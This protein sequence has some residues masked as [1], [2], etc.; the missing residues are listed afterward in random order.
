[1]HL[2]DMV[3][4]RAEAGPDR[5]AIFDS[6]SGLSYGALEAGAEGLARALRDEGVQPGARVAMLARNTPVYPLLMI[7][8]AKAGGIFVPLNTRAAAGTL[9]DLLAHCDPA[10]L[11][12]QDEF[13]PLLQQAMAGARMPRLVV[14]DVDNRA[15]WAR[16]A[17]A[18]DKPLPPLGRD[19]LPG[20]IMYTSGTTG[21]PKGVVTS[22]RNFIHLLDQHVRLCGLRPEDRL[23]LAMP[24]YHNGG[25]A[26]VM[27]AGLR[28]GAAVA[29]FTG[30]FA[31]ETVLAAAQR[32][33]VSVAHWIPTML[34]R[35]V[36]VMEATPT[37]LPA[38]RSVQF[39]AMPITPAL[40]ARVRAAFPV[41]LLQLYGTT[42]CG[43]VACS[44]D[45]RDPGH[46]GYMRLAADSGVRV[47]DDTGAD[48]PVGGSGEV[49]VTQAQSGMIGYWQAPEQ[50]ATAVRNGQVHTGD[51]ARNLGGGR[52]ALVGRRDGMI[53][54]GGE[55]L[56]PG[57]VENAL[58]DHPALREVAVVGVEDPDLGQRVCAVV[59]LRPGAEVTLDDLRAHCAARIPGFM[60][61]RVLRVIAE[62][63]RTATGKISRAEVI[64]L[65]R[66]KK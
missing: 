33:Q 24:L 4:R 32:D 54:S 42:D 14:L 16:V 50:T 64:A 46:A 53:I 58:A 13:L 66:Q 63:P 17:A 7:A 62:L 23:Q 35:L 36:E 20:M 30:S 2:S 49:V 37:A 15:L 43:L 65:A 27:G 6:A 12:V 19:D 45:L 11:V 56:Y 10:V 1:M 39:G 3:V 44:D 40:L 21:A 29:C 47:L 61:P 28:A 41:E 22:H 48:A 18:S 31:A 59:S 8:T 38:L 34:N 51:M 25:M 26:A 5:L 9:R 55:N 60:H 52:I 57:E